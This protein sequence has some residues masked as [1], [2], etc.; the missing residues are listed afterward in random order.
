MDSR[1]KLFF[2]PRQSLSTVI[3]LQ[4]IWNRDLQGICCKLL[5]CIPR[6]MVLMAIDMYSKM[7]G[8][9]SDDSYSTIKRIYY[10]E[11]NVIYL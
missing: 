7:Y 5:I 9:Y 10:D 1:F 4:R 8:S 11:N 2:N 3:I 6:C